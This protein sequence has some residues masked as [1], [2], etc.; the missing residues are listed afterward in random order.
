M[1]AHELREQGPRRVSGRAPVGTP[2][3]FEGGAG[4]GQSALTDAFAFCAS[5]TGIE[6]KRFTI[7]GQAVSFRFASDSLNNAVGKSLSN[8]VGKAF[9]HLERA[10]DDEPALQIDLWESTAEAGRPP[11]PATEAGGQAPGAMY[12]YR[13]EGVEAVYQ[14]GL[15]VMCAL[16]LGARRAWYWTA[17][18][19]QLPYWERATPLRQIL[20][21]WLGSSGR[22]QVHGGAVGNDDGG[23]LVVGNPGSGKST[24]TLAC[25]GSDLL[26]AGDD[27]VAVEVEPSPW[28][29]SLYSSGKVEP[30]HV[31][32][33]P[34]VRA[35]LGEAAVDQDKAVV[36]VHEHYP[37]ATAAGF[38]LRAILLPRV[39]TR[40]R[41]KIFEAS[42][43]AALRALAP[44]TIVQLHTAGRDALMTM[45]LLV[46]RVPSYVFELG[47]DIE[48]IPD[49]IAEFLRD[50]PRGDR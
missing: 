26:F 49:T 16:E 23:V 31:R 28:I 29:H 9:A 41:P 5:S 46:R 27:Y 6:E 40:E 19:G 25:L 18:A 42:A 17:D 35:A 50:L 10:S 11:L 33:L 8:A 3:A 13:D 20:H 4:I 1:A 30:D 7:A 47:R 15:G 34:Q 43:A 22:Q 36:Y 37:E 39:T 12:H 21:W 2:T 38:P 44:S 14:P 32:R 45:S 48:A 24:T